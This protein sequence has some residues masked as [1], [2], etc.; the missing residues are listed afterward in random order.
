MLP[1]V[2]TVV[3]MTM[4]VTRPVGMN[5]FVGMVMIVG[6]VMG[7]MVIMTVADTVATQMIM[8]LV[9]RVIMGVIAVVGMAAH[10]DFLPSLKVKHSG[11]SLVSASAMTAHQATSSS[12]SMLLMFNSS[13]CNRVRRREPQLHAVNSVW[14]TSSRAQESQRA[15]PSIFL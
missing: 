11:A 5:V 12:S 15:R 3:C 4:A 14:V 7:V 10:I 9:S 2:I 13:P 8:L 6:A 1:A